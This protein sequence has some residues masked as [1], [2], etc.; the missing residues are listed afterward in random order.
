MFRLMKMLIESGKDKDVMT[1]RIN[2]LYGGGKLSEAEKD[3]LLVMLQT[4]ENN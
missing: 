2:V 4:K 1:T 3:E